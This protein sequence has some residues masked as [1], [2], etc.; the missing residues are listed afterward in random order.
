MGFFERLFFYALAV[1]GGVCTG[2]YMLGTTEVAQAAAEVRAEQLA[3]EA[4]CQLASKLAE[5]GL[6]LV[7]AG[8]E[9]S[10]LLPNGEPVEEAQ[11]HCAL[12]DGR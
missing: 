1:A 3:L 10:L 12:L 5:I 2:M 11:F 7:A 4:Q 6:R 9:V 8:Q